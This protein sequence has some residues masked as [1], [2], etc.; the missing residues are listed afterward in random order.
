M[1][2]FAGLENLTEWSNTSV[3]NFK[4]WILLFIF[5]S[6]WVLKRYS[7]LILYLFFIFYFFYRNKDQ[8]VRKLV[9]KCKCTF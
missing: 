9:H 2:E 1:I 4:S 8:M 5:S 6:L 3:I 7:I